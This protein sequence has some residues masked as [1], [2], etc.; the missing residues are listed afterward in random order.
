MFER[1]CRFGWYDKLV[2]VIGDE[3]TN[4]LISSVIISAI[5][6]PLGLLLYWIYGGESGSSIFTY[7]NLGFWG[8]LAIFI[9]CFV[10]C[11]LEFR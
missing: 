3:A 1:L 4:A 11:M 10:G 6:T 5:L 2:Q 9:I 7:L 8:F